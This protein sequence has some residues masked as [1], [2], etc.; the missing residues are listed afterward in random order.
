MLLG[1]LKFEL[2]GNIVNLKSPVAQ[3]TSSVIIIPVFGQESKRTQQRAASPDVFHLVANISQHK[4]GHLP[5]LLPLISF[6]SIYFQLAFIALTQPALSNPFIY[7]IRAA[8]EA[9]LF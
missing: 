5:V 1:D 2:R 3:F 8:A 6:T 4:A 7:S 9:F